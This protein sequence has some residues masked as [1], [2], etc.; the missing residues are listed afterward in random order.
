[1]DKLQQ[2]YDAICAGQYTMASGLIEK[3]EGEGEGGAALVRVK[4]E[5]LLQ[6]GREDAAAV[7]LEDFL[8]VQAEPELYVALGKIYARQGASKRE[9]MCYRSAVKLE[10][11]KVS[12]IVPV[13]KV[14]TFLS[15]CLDSIA[16]QT[17]R[18]LEIIV[19]D[20][21]SPDRC[22]AICDEYAQRDARFLVLHQRN[23]GVGAARNVGLKKASGHFIAFVDSDDWIEPD[24][25]F[26]LLEKALAYELDIVECGFRYVSDT[27]SYTD[28]VGGF[29]LETLFENVSHRIQAD[30][31]VVWNVLYR[32]NCIADV[33]FPVDKKYDDLFF[34]YPALLHATRF[35]RLRV[36]LYNYFQNAC[37]EVHQA[38]G[39]RSLDAV[40]GYILRLRQMERLST[41]L[42]GMAAE[43]L[44]GYMFDYLHQTLALED[45]AE[46]QRCL[47]R[48]YGQAESCGIPLAPAGVKGNPLT[49][50]VETA[51]VIIPFLC[52]EAPSSVLVVGAD[53]AHAGALI[54]RVFSLLGRPL[55][56][57]EISLGEKE[58]TSTVFS[59]SYPLEALVGPSLPD[60]YDCVVVTDLFEQVEL[61]TAKLLLN[62]LLAQAGRSVLCTMDM[63]Q[64]GQEGLRRRYHPAAFFDF[65]FSY[66]APPYLQSGTQ[67]YA[68]YPPLGRPATREGRNLSETFTSAGSR[69]F[70]IAYLL[71]HKKLT[72]GLKAL[73][74]QMRQMYRRGNEVYAVYRNMPGEEGNTAALPTW[75]DLDPATD[76][77]GQLVLQPAEAY[78]T[79]LT[80]FDAVMIGF[81][82][83]LA[84]FLQPCG[85]PVVYWEQGYELLYGDAGKLL[86]SGSQTLH[87]MRSLY[88]APVNYL[89][90][91]RQ[92]SH[93]LGSR[94][95][96]TADILDNGID[97]NF[98]HP[99]P[100]KEFTGTVLLVGNPYLPFKGF[101]FALMVLQKIW[102]L[103]YRFQ[104]NWACQQKPQCG[105]FEF[106]V[107][108]FVM[109]PQNVL[110][111]LYR[112]ADVFLFTSLYESFPLPPFEAMASGTPVVAADCGGIRTYARP[113]ENI[114]LFD[115]GDIDSAAG[116]MIAVLQNE[117]VR[118]NLAENGRKTAE[119]YSFQRV[120]ANL[121]AY[122]CSR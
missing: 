111:E 22:G 44:L 14:E 4:T 67:F 116:A 93:I 107:R 113:G 90:V 79:V 114:L 121:E 118:K 23:Q 58:E 17:Y 43:K 7:L 37:S 81:C 101:A 78:H 95:G 69:K 105:G 91:S 34:I 57:G 32:A 66:C 98:Y 26:S 119:N 8:S 40:E 88:R 64:N 73:L 117:S 13:Y 100:Q 50:A 2:I 89:A 94:F 103:G 16:A 112:R 68:F 102:Q 108:Y 55:R 9:E 77:S 31:N 30:T 15:R 71:P 87:A 96:L 36:P 41:A 21:G 85:I 110:A 45:Q 76:L 28:A 10:R 72:G 75:C 92:V 5:L 120:A 97:L 63:L 80:G 33:H 35:G 70:R 106:P 1:M 12:F 3:Q 52:K 20:D 122:L 49:K 60:T 39:I 42:Y 62:N 51:S 65:D 38:F 99:V 48:L 18:N 11:D 27:G 6:T 29:S 53:T 83:Q 109:E 115:Q 82:S 104:V 54:A 84:E 46:R 19:V 61:D 59:R 47:S 24:Y 56:L 25:V 86:E 74:E